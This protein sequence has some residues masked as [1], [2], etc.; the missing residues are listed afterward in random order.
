MKSVN[1]VEDEYTL[2]K[3]EL[4]KSAIIK[5]VKC[6]EAL[7][8]RIFDLGIIKNSIITPIYKSPFGDPTAYMVKNAVIALRYKDC[9]DIVVT[10]L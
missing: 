10:P 4:N 6:K 5:D 1:Y 7:K 8:N 3:V 9:Q 2:N